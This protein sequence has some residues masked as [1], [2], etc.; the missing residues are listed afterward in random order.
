MKRLMRRL[1][2]WR[3]HDER[4]RLLQEEMEF[5]LETLTQQFIARG[6]PEHEARSAARRKFGNMEQTSE[7][8]R[9][10]WIARWAGDLLQDLRYCF[11]GMRRQAGFTAF[12]V[13]I[14][15]LGI[16][17][18]ATVYSVVNTL[19]LRP[20][21][22]RDPTRL[23]WIQNGLSYSLQSDHFLDLRA[24]TKSFSDMAGWFNFYSI[25]NSKLTGAGEPERLTS[26]QVTQNFFSLLGIPLALG[27]SFSDAECRAPF[28]RPPVAVLGN[29][30]W[31]RKFSSDPH[32]LG[33][34]VILNDAPVI[35]VGV[36]PASF[37]FGS[38]LAPGNTIDL[39]LPL[40]LTDEFN[41]RGNTM[42]VIARLNPGV[43][44]SSAQ[45]EFTILG[46]QL[47]AQYPRRNGIDPVL[48]PLEKHVSG[49]VRPALLVLAGAVGVVMLIV[50]A[51]LSSLQMARM[52]SRRKEMA[53][54]T[55]LGAARHRL[56]RQALTESVALSFCG[57]LLGLVLAFAGT[58]ALAHLTAFRLPLLASV[59]LDGDALA[60]TLLAAFLTGILFGLL[61]AVQTPSFTAQD[62][63]KDNTRSTAGSLSHTWLRNALVVSEVA[64]ACVLLVGAGLLIR[65]FLRVVDTDLGFQPDRA[66]SI[67]VDPSSQFRAKEKRSGYFDEVLQRV[68]NIPDVAEAGLTDVLPFDG[69]RS[70]GVSGKGQIYPQGHYPEAFIRIVSEGYTEAAGI[71][72]KAGR[73]LTAR[74]NSASDKVVVINESLART[75]WPGQNAVG[76]FMNQDGGRQVI[77]VVGDV[78]HLAAEEAGGNE[79]YIPIRQTNDYDEVELVVRTALPAAT[80]A[81]AVRAALRPLDR[82]MPLRDFRA[83]RDLVDHASSPRRF[84]VWL[85]GGFASFAL[86]LASLGIYALISYSVSQRVQEIGIRMALGA[87]A[88]NLQTAILRQ[89][90]ILTGAGLA[91]GL[92]AS[93]LLATFIGSMLFGVTAGD[94]ATFVAMAGLM[95]LV[96]LLAGF[97]PAR[98]ATRID[99]MV[100]LR[101]A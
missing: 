31:K 63:L 82:N 59:R 91:L 54:R 81:N 44:V 57:A 58:R 92:I 6:L 11:R 1:R 40:P 3:R 48:N 52:T 75:V 90:L 43:T 33:R 22:Y 74:D 87:T 20:L 78:R 10:T 29:A 60:F 25:G 84:L 27:R 18:S 15:G 55:A 76:Q 42:A 56:L 95:S 70:W 35:V 9:A 36:L 65:S 53:V 89:T 64:F 41:R 37:D 101:V 66:Y 67:R 5:H 12:V 85:L 38:V 100:A 46:R 79:M 16:G 69:D 8:A 62:E 97:I 94:P 80:A 83:L 34:K 99:P 19:L 21:P 50:C 86:L 49:R 26:V 47:E 71:P 23:V 30:F 72:L 93:R 77:G 2:Y 98:R 88:A 14:A 61:P 13:L 68:K 73:T 4:H 17:A 96:A 32:I 24:R 51:N 45:A 28:Y 7:E 39:F